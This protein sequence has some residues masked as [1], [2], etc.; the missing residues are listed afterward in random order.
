MKTETF[1]EFLKKKKK[2]KEEPES[3]W[4][5]RERLWINSVTDFYNNVKR[6]L[7]PFVKEGLLIIKE[8]NWT[9]TDEDYS[10]QYDIKKINIIIGKNDIVTLTPRGKLVVGG[11]GRID[12]KGP[13]G[14]ISIIH[15][16][17]NKWKFK[18]M[19][20]LSEFEDVTA[21]SFEAVI[22]DLVND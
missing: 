14:A 11:Y 1:E 19:V 3:D 17:G 15:K 16:N 12:M 4:A 6:W 7:E 10:G 5:Q 13:K 2:E 18:N 9:N 22:Q 20:T 8:D 21:K